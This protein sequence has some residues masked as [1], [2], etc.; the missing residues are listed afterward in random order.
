MVGQLVLGKDFNFVVREV[1]LGQIGALLENHNTK[2]VSGE[3]LGQDPTGG[4]GA[5]ND[6]IHLVRS[7]VFGLVHGHFFSASFAADSQPG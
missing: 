4:T 1:G 2:A 7:F 3:F 5:H 6:E